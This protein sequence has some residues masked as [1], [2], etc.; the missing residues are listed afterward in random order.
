[1][2][3]INVKFQKKYIFK[4]QARKGNLTA[5]ELKSFFCHNEE[6]P[7][8]LDDKHHFVYKSIEL[9]EAFISFFQTNGTEVKDDFTFTK[10][11]RLKAKLSIGAYF[12]PFQLDM[13]GHRNTIYVFMMKNTKINEI[14]K[15]FQNKLQLSPIKFKYSKSF[16]KPETMT[17][18]ASINSYKVNKFITIILPNFK[19]FGFKIEQSKI[20]LFYL[21]LSYKTPIK[22]IQGRVADEINKRFK[23]ENHLTPQ[24]IQL[25]LKKNSP[26]TNLASQ[27][28]LLKEQ[29]K[30]I[31]V[32]IKDAKLPANP[33]YLFLFPESS[34]PKLFELDNDVTVE[35][36]LNDNVPNSK[37]ASLFCNGEKLKK[38]QKFSELGITMANLIIV[39]YKGSKTIITIKLPHESFQIKFKNFYQI[40][41]L[42]EKVKEKIGSTPF[43]LFYKDKKLDENKTCRDYGI[44]GTAE[45]SAQ[46]LKTMSSSG[47][48]LLDNDS[49][50][51]IFDTPVEGNPVFFVAKD[52]RPLSHTFEK[53][54]TVAE[55]KEF[56]MTSW[57]VKNIDFL[58]NGHFISEKTK[59][60]KLPISKKIP[61]AV[62]IKDNYNDILQIK[63]ALSMANEVNS[64]ALDMIC[65]NNGQIVTFNVKY[66]PTIGDVLKSI[67]NKLGISEGHIDIVYHDTVCSDKQMLLS[68]IEKKGTTHNYNSSEDEESVFIESFDSDSDDSDSS[69][70]SNNSE[71]ENNSSESDQDKKSK[72]PKKNIKKTKNKESEEDENNEDDSDERDDEENDNKNDDEDEEKPTRKSSDRSKDD[73]TKQ[74]RRVHFHTAES[75]ETE[76]EKK[77]DKEEK[78]D[79]KVKNK[80]KDKYDTVPK[81]DKNKEKEGTEYKKDRNKD[82]EINETKKEKSKDKDDT[83]IMRDKNK[84]KDKQESKKDEIKQ[85]KKNKDKNDKNDDVNNEDFHEDSIDEDLSRDGNYFYFR[86]TLESTSTEQDYINLYS[87]FSNRHLRRVSKLK[88]KDLSDASVL[89]NSLNPNNSK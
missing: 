56:I 85:K 65:E 21:N 54:A 16:S 46:L 81:K 38:N 6:S 86:L 35:N 61:I 88:I 37:D 9:E 12:Y 89:K 3:T 29:D 19:T 75:S 69:N 31:H 87:K 13:N 32:V 42:K 1:M 17:S 28:K 34:V 7:F 26:L 64:L 14:A 41:D 43:D 78:E 68:Q 47:T 24:N 44:D 39:K 8:K 73:K 30:I 72:S 77:K 25:F 5:G 62:V 33:S 59:L 57:M 55:A 11:I 70:G 4:Y 60:S 82:K 58:L 36:F 15:L 76:K 63:E 48:L 71:E 2:F 18:N 53:K 40:R 74:K 49:S 23:M 84:S 79:K 22:V 10:D 80:D 83:E 52:R 67:Q 66:N 45:I 51:S 20:P 27:I 50:L